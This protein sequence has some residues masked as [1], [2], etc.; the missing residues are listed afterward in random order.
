MEQV[1]KNITVIVAILALLVSSSGL[2]FGTNMLDRFMGS[3]IVMQTYK[4][5]FNIPD[6]LLENIDSSIKSELPD[7]VRFITIKN[8]GSKSSKNLKLVIEVSGEIFQENIS[9]TEDIIIEKE[10]DRII[11]LKL[12]RLSKNAEIKTSIWVKNMNYPFIVSYADDQESGLV[13]EISVKNNENS[14]ETPFFIAILVASLATLLIDKTNKYMNRAISESSKERKQ[15]KALLDRQMLGNDIE[16]DVVDV[17]VSIDDIEKA[18][19][20]LKELLSKSKKNQI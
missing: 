16:E 2:I 8:S 9:S 1:K 11:V 5:D 4:D 12:D 15:F 18:T 10:G 14:I 7:S 20:E 6:K 13:E 19:S 3:K 17:N